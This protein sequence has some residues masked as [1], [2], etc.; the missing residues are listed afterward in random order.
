VVFGSGQVERGGGEKLAA[1]GAMMMEVGE[2]EIPESPRSGGSNPKSE[3][4]NSRFSCGLYWDP[5]PTE[6][7]TM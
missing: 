5:I 1:P 4:I 3:R 7:P 2:R 6:L